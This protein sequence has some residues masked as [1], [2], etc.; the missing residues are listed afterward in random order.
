MRVIVSARDGRPYGTE[1]GIQRIRF[2]DQT[3]RRQDGESEEE[4]IARAR[5]EGPKDDDLPREG[6]AGVYRP[7]FTAD[8]GDVDA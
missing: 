1:N 5:A 8:Y 2:G 4:F 6:M 7:R 3:W